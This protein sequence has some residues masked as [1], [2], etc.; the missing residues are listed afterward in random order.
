MEVLNFLT[1]ESA[2]SKAHQI[3]L[4][5]ISFT[6]ANI[7]PNSGTIPIQHDKLSKIGTAIMIKVTK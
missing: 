7:K 6:S 2:E 3:Y 5:N 4:K 1:A